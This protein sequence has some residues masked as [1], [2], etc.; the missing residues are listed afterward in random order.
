VDLE[1]LGVT[2][3]LS[4]AVSYGSD[5]ALKAALSLAFIVVLLAL[6]WGIA[7]AIRR[8]GPP[9]SDS[10]LWWISFVRNAGL[11]LILIGLFVI[12]QEEIRS[13]ALS[14]AAVAVAL[15]VATKELLLCLAGALWRGFTPSFS[16]G[17]WV[18]IGPYSGEVI[19]GTPLAT[20]LQEIDPEDFEPTG[21]VVAA[22][23]S[24]LLSHAVINHGFRKRFTYLDF[25]IYSEPRDDAEA[26]R[27]R[28]EGA[29][30]EASGEFQEIARRYA[31][32]IEKSTGARLRP[33]EANVVLSTTDLAK[34]VFR[35]RVFSPRERAPALRQV[36]MRAFLE[37]GAAQP[38][39][40]PPAA[41]SSIAASVAS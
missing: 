29:L 8:G 36:A 37:T 12:W 13:A 21:R 31:A 24:L 4:R 38:A 15:V 40:A 7:R 14:L 16:V 28:I 22:P 10:K 26:V 27:A 41:A 39:A 9:L 5:E 17:D 1:T 19:E 18:E 23:N 32:R 34:L 25:P 3:D 2:G 6:R 35:C 11:G 30:A 20:V 33:A